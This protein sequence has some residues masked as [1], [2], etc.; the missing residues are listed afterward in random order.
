[1]KVIN[2]S[3]IEDKK[4]KKVPAGP[5]RT[6]SCSDVTG[7]YKGKMKTLISVTPFLY[8]FA[9]VFVAKRNWLQPALLGLLQKS[10]PIDDYS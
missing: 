8:G 9:A 5:L 1:M 3:E 10:N 2:L 4:K 7:N 6:P